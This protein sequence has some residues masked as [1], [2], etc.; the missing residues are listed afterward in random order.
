MA[1][2][3]SGDVDPGIVCE[4]QRYVSG[5]GGGGGLPL[6]GN[7]HQWMD[8]L[9]SKMKSFSKINK[10]FGPGGVLRGV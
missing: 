7:T 9:H 3:Q 5:G 4:Q 1:V 2:F 6:V 10:C 8:R